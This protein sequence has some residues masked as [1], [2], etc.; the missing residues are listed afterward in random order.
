MSS[1]ARVKESAWVRAAPAVARERH[2][3]LV[4][5]RLEAGEHVFFSVVGGL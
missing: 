5:A 1:G 3:R 4:F 2:V